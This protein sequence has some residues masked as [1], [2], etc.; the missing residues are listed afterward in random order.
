M[1]HIAAQ[2]PF[3][4]LASLPAFSSDASDCINANKDAEG[5]G[6]PK[7]LHSMKPQKTAAEFDTRRPS[8]M[9]EGHLVIS[10]SSL[11]GELRAVVDVAVVVS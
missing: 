6:Y 8:E 2:F 9:W 11:D 7:L 10:A 3:P 1:R 5:T 4:A